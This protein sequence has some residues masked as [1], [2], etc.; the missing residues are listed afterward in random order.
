MEASAFGAQHGKYF[1]ADAA[2]GGEFKLSGFGELADADAVR[3]G[4]RGASAEDL[5]AN[6][7][8]K[9]IDDADA[10]EG[11][12]ECSAAFAE[13]TIYFPSTT[14][15]TECAREVDLSFSADDDVVGELAQRGEFL[16]AGALGREDD[17]RR[18]VMAKNFRARIDG[19]GAADDDA[20]VVFGE[21][22]LHAQSLESKSAGIKFGVALLDGARAGHDGVGSGAKFVEMCEIMLAAEGGDGAIGRGDLA[23]GGHGHVDEDEGAGR[24]CGS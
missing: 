1:F 4:G 2:E 14:Q 17:D 23:L 19:T 9:L 18:E 10:D 3:D 22:V 11:V 7:E 21:A 8:V 6:R 12:V 13:E 20:E 15:V 24:V 16:R 5:R